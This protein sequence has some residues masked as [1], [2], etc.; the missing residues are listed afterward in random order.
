M[1]KL[2]NIDKIFTLNNG[3]R[4]TIGHNR[5]I[6]KTL[7]D[8]AMRYVCRLHGHPVM[9][10]ALGSGG[11]LFATL[12]DCGYCTR[13]TAQAMQDFANAFGARLSVSIAGG[14]L[15]LRWYQDGWKGREA[16]DGR[17]AITMD[18]YA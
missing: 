4:I 16:I 1:A 3:E 7:L 5:T 14:D 13:T 17:A 2:R 15:S 6:E 9:T 8:G 10:A 12:D 11:H 18:R